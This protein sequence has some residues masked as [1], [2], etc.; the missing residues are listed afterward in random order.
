MS[1]LEAAAS[2]S[3]LPKLPL[4]R[5]LLGTNLLLTPPH[6][7]LPQRSDVHFRGIGK[8]KQNSI[9]QEIEEGCGLW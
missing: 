4:V 8:K 7:P 5:T 1:P 6:P 9:S 2:A 3:A